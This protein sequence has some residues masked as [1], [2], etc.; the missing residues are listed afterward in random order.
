MATAELDIGAQD[1]VVR[2]HNTQSRSG[3]THQLELLVQGHSGL[4]RINLH[5]STA[6]RL[7]EVC[8]GL[9]KID[10]DNRSLLVNE[11]PRST[12]TDRTEQQRD[13]HGRD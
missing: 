1:L 13:N 5:F 7:D 4:V 12:E 3:S 11:S 10:I 8:G 2:A 9:R 6:E